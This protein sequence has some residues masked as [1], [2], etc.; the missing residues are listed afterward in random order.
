MYLTSEISKSIEICMSFINWKNRKKVK[1]V[2]IFLIH[3][4]FGGSGVK[5]GKIDKEG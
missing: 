2:K 3:P 5:I 4:F 1:I